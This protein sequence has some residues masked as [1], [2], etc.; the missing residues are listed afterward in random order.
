MAKVENSRCSGHRG[1]I[2]GF[3]EWILLLLLFWARLMAEGSFTGTGPG[4]SSRVDVAV[5][6]KF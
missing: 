1:S 2:Q 5:A 4:L 3:V 6:S